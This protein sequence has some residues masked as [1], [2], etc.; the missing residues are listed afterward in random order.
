MLGDLSKR[1]E[2]GSCKLMQ[3]SSPE[4]GVPEPV[5]QKSGMMELPNYDRTSNPNKRTTAYTCA[6]IGSDLQD[7]EFE[8]VSLKKFG[9]TL[10]KG[11]MMW[12]HSL[13]PD[14]MNSLTVPAD[15]STEAHVD[16]IEAETGEP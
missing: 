8:P 15:S 11:T 9:E 3:Q 1:I 4:V 2:S 14:I 16:A 5:S 12:P 13:A 7:D 6:G 10:S